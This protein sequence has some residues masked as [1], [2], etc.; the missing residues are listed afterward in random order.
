MAQKVLPFK[1]ETTNDVITPHAGLAVFGEFIHA[2]DVINQ[3]NRELPAPGSNRGYLPALFVVPLLLMLHGGGRSLEDLRKIR[4]DS[5]LQEILKMKALPSSDAT[6][7]WLVRIGN[8]S[9]LAGLQ[10]VNNNI[11][12]RAIKRDANSEFTLD[13]DAT[14]IVAEKHDANITYKG[15]KGYMPIVGHLAEN[16][17]VIG[18]EFREG[19]VSPSTRNLEFIQHCFQQMPKRNQITALR[20]D[21]ATY[22]ADIFNWCEENSIQFAIGGRLDSATKKT[23][24]NIDDNDWEQ[25]GEKQ[26]AETVH[27]MEK[28]KKAFRLI[29]IKHPIQE[30]LP[31][32]ELNDEQTATVPVRYSVI[33][34]NRHEAAAE[35]ITWYNKRGDT[36]ENRIKDLKIG[37][38]MERMP[39]GTLAA[40]STFFR[41]GVLAYNLF[42]LFKMT[43]LPQSM[44]HCQIQTIRWRLYQTAGKIVKHAGAIALK[45]S[46]SMYRLLNE[47]R[48]KN[49]EEMSMS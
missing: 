29:V 18:D 22:Q 24:A 13:I 11:V 35:V 14:Q 42:V 4:A 43:A 21:S 41:I 3:I 28:T 19:N 6:G 23:I 25:F 5:G 37:F 40:N 47:I 10:K 12:R 39:C 9:G 34:T 2:T 44:Q 7:A 36:S 46:N 31:L 32:K 15:E 27:S 8:N 17:L 26:I 33:A 1:L 45:V 30:P 38:G 48:A 20:A 49:Y 16:G